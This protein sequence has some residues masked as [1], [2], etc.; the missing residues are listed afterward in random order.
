[1]FQTTGGANLVEKSTIFNLYTISLNEQ[2]NRWPGELMKI[3]DTM[4]GYHR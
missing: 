3:D 4:D 1:M 2:T